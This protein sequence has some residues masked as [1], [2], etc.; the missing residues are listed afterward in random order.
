MPIGSRA[1]EIIE[2]LAASGGELVTKDQLIGTVWPGM[3]VGDNTLQVHISAIRKAL[4]P[5]RAMLKTAPGRGYRLLGRWTSRPPARMASA[6]P[7][8][9]RTGGDPVQGNLPIPASDLIGRDGVVRHVRD[10]MSAYRVVTLTGPGG[11]GKSRLALEAARLAAPDF[12]GDA[13]LVELASVSD[14]GLVAAAVAA[15]LGLQ[16]VA[17]DISPGALARAI[18]GRKLLLLIDNCEHLIDAAA[19]LVDTLVRLCPAV[20]VLA[21]SREF[22][23]IEG[24]CVYRVPPLRFPRPASGGTGAGSNPGTQRDQAV[25]RPRVGAAIGR[26]SS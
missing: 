22:M 9:V 21:T 23:R 17:N 25:H 24:E 13:W 20:A 5:D 8:P 10:L 12:A 18:G 3:I 6:D 11:I 16:L 1:F 19:T 14:A 2:A 15:V 4:G 7:A 26:P